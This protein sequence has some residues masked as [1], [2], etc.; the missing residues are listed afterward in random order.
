MAIPHHRLI[1]LIEDFATGCGGGIL[2]A[3]LVRFFWRRK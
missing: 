1:E 2:G 3:L